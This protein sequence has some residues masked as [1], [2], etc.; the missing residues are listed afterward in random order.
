MNRREELEEK[1]KFIE[2]SIKK[3]S[4]SIIVVKPDS[5]ITKKKV[6]RTFSNRA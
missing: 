6:G 1:M 5:E 4:N 2:Q 3:L